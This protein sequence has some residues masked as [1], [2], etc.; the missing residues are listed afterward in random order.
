MKYGSTTLSKNIISLLYR[1]KYTNIVINYKAS[2]IIIVNYT[3]R[4]RHDKIPHR[5]NIVGLALKQITFVD[6]GGSLLI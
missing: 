1:V 2:S 6:V 3:I 4:V 5:G